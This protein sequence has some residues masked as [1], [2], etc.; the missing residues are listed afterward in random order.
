MLPVIKTD[1]LEELLI[2]FYRSSF[3]YNWQ[4]NQ[5]RQIG[6]TA[7]RTE[8]H[9]DLF[10]TL[11]IGVSVIYAGQEYV[12]QQANPKQTGTLVT[13]DISAT[14]VM[15]ECQRKVWQYDTK[16]TDDNPVSLGP[17]DI[18]HWFY[19]GNDAGFTWEIRGAFDKRSM[20]GVTGSGKDALDLIV[21]K[22][23]AHIWADNKHII[24]Y[25]ADNFKKVTDKQFRF[26]HNT[27]EISATID[28]TSIT[29][30]TMC[31]PKKNEDGSYVFPPFLHQNAESVAKWGVCKGAPVN[32]ERFS[33]QEALGT[34]AESQ[35]HPDPDVN[36]SL[37]YRG[38]ED[39]FEGESWLFIAP[40]MGFDADVT[41]LGLQK[42]PYYP[43]SKPQI[44]LSNTLRDIRQIQQQIAQQ[45][46]QAHTSYGTALSLINDVESSQ[47]GIVKVGEI[48][49]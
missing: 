30:T 7:Y 35:L 10:D 39:V 48:S 20:S 49:G 41:V 19:D 33:N 2:D 37:T 15:Y 26:Y 17:G 44:T 14:H 13:K 18:M 45:A 21:S 24:I 32:D 29:N 6:F 9:E 42:Y 12:V 31:Y 46:K 38:N 11:Q 47:I 36:L 23:D 3:A 40:L 22:W 16:G 27:D 43:G 4:N 8:N 5:Q 1:S 34:Y 28:G 25:D